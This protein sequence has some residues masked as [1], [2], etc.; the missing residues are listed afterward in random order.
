MSFTPDD[1]AAL[2]AVRSVTLR[3][4]EQIESVGIAHLQV[5]AAQEA[6]PL[7]QEIARRNGLCIRCGSVL[8]DAAVREAIAAARAVLS[9]R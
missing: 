7:S 4:I 8:P 5:L 6:G 9:G 1:R 2:L 3:V